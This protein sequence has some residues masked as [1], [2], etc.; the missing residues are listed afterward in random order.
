MQDERVSTYISGLD[1]WRRD[2]LVRLRDL[3][4]Q[5]VPEIGED[6]KWDT[7]VFVKGGNVCALGVFSD[8]VKVNF[9]KGASLADPDGLFNAGLEAKT[10]RAIDLWEGDV[11][12][13]DS[14]AFQDL[15]RR[16]AGATYAPGD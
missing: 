12:R 7:P 6:W 2:A 13:L 1:G 5:A 4:H 11:E 16:A 14:A 8:H 9:L 15:V 10:S 3:I